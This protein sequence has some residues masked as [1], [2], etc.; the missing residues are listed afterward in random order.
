[1]ECYAGDL[2]YEFKGN[3]KSFRETLIEQGITYP[4]GVREDLN[5]KIFR[6]RFKQIKSNLFIPSSASYEP[7][8]TDE[9]KPLGRGYKTGDMLGEGTV[10][11]SFYEFIFFR[12]DHVNI[13]SILVWQRFRRI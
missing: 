1:M 9:F 13:S 4:A 8:S 2:L 7:K 10:S 12:R 3:T 5:K 11:I 6:E